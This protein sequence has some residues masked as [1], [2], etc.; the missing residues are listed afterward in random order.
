MVLP[1]GFIN[2]SVVFQSYIHYVLVGFLNT[3]CICYLDDILIFSNNAVEYSCY[4]LNWVSGIG[5]CAGLVNVP[6]H[7]VNRVINTIRTGVCRLMDRLC[8]VSPFLLFSHTNEFVGIDFPAPRRVG[9]SGLLKVGR[10]VYEGA[11][12][13]STHPHSSNHLSWH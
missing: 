11:E 3:F 9:A 6:G 13:T 7:R 8:G 4:L 5:L 12:Q 1:F 10:W 2:A